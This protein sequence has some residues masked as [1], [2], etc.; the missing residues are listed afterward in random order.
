MSRAT[1]LQLVRDLTLFTPDEGTIDR[2]Y[3]ESVHEID[4]FFHEISFF[5][6]TLPQATFTLPEE[7]GELLQV[8]YDARVLDKT[9]IGD[10]RVISTQWRDTPGEPL[11]YLTQNETERTWRLAPTPSL[12][13]TPPLG[14]GFFGVNFPRYNVLALYTLHAEE[15]I[16]LFDLL[17]AHRILSREF[18]RESQHQDLQYA[19]RCELIY[20][21]LLSLL[22]VNHATP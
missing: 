17:L 13:S 6:V 19:E 21:I 18:S 14:F 2:Y 11:V 22:T 5:S 20:S 15:A 8:F 4:H 7:A 1:T 16:D 12:T 3:T 10:Y 9:S